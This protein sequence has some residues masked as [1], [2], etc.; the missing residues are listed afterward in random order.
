MG[1]HVHVF[2]AVGRWLVNPSLLRGH[3]EQLLAATGDGAEG[4][5][6]SAGHQAGLSSGVDGLAKDLSA[7][8]VNAH[9]PPDKQL[10]IYDPRTH[11]D[12]EVWKLKQRS[13]QGLQAKCDPFNV[14]VPICFSCA[15]HRAM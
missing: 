6:L 10:I 15:K 4:I 3:V 12:I 2:G 1:T 5:P 7:L 9:F 11:A 14:E 13:A 8:H